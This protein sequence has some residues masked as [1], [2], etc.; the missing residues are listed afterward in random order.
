MSITESHTKRPLRDGSR[1]SSNPGSEFSSPSDSD[2]GSVSGSGSES[3]GVCVK[4]ARRGDAARKRSV[5]KQGAGESH[6]KLAKKPRALELIKRKL[7]IMVC[8]ELSSR[9][10]AVTKLQYRD[11]LIPF[12]GEILVERYRT[13]INGAIDDLQTEYGALDATTLSGTLRSL[14]DVTAEEISQ[15]V[16]CKNSYKIPAYTIFQVNKQCLPT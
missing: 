3:E 7:R 1:V 10:T 14:C 8:S 16:S 4:S 2:T 12:F 6:C 5:G 13:K 11:M 9:R 15:I